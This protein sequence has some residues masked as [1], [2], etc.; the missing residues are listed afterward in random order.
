MKKI[1]RESL[2]LLF[3]VF[4][5]LLFVFLWKEYWVTP[6]L[7]RSLKEAMALPSVQKPVQQWQFEGQPNRRTPMHTSILEMPKIP[8]QPNDD[9][10]V[11]SRIFANRLWPIDGLLNVQSLEKDNA[12]L[13][14][15]MRQVASLSEREKF[16]ALEEWL[17]GN[18]GSRWA[19]ALKNELMGFKHK[20]GWFDVARQG[21]DE[22]WQKTKDRTDLPAYHLA[23]GVLG[24]LLEA[25]IGISRAQK[26]RELVAAADARPLNGA[27]EGKVFRAREAVWLL[28]HTAA[29]NVMCGPLALNAIKEF[30]REPFIAP[31]LSQVP[32]DYQQT[33][34]PLSEVQRY[35]QNDYHLELAMARRTDPGA[36][37]P[38]P[39]V[40]HVKDDHFNALL[41]VSADGT[42]YF[43]EDR[44]L[45]FAG[46]V[47]K[48]AVDQ[49]AT[50]YFLVAANDLG[51]GWDKV[52]AVTGSTVFGRDGAHGTT[53][54]E[55]TV[56]PYSPT[57]DPGVT[58]GSVRGGGCAGMPR[59][60]FLPMPG[61]IRIADIPLNYTPP[62]GPA[63]GFQINYNDM[64]SG[65]PTSPPTW[66]HVGVT[67]STN[68]VAWVEHVG[69]AL[70]NGTNL[71]VRLPGGGTEVVRYST[72]TAKFGPHDRSFATVTRTGTFTYTREL[73]DGSV[74][75]YNAP[76]HPTTPT[77]VFLSQI[78]D[79]QGNALTMAYDASIR[80]VSVTDAIGQVTTLSYTDAGNIYR[81]TQVTDPFG[82]FAT[83]TYDAG[84]R[85]TSVTDQINLASTFTYAAS[86]F[87]E[88]M[89]T[90]YGTSTFAKL[91]DSAGSNRIV[92]ATDPLG[93]KERVEFN[94]T[95]STFIPSLRSPPKSVTVGGQSVSFYAEDSRLQFR[96]GW[97]W[98]KLQSQVAPGD[99]KA[100]RNY[101]FYTNVN[102]Q[103]VPV[104]EN[105]KEPH[106]DRVWYN[107]PGGILIDSSG[108]PYY[109]GA[110]AAP[111]KVL[112]MLPDGTPQL[113]QTYTNA[114]G[115][116]IKSVD[117]LG[118]TTEYV[119][120]ANGLDVIEIKQTTGG[121][122]ERQRSIS[123]NARHLPLTIT[124]AAG[125]V[126]TYTYNARGQVLTLT[127]ALG[128]ATTFSYDA[129]G[130]LTSMDG[131]LPGASDTTTLT[132][133]AVGRIRTTTNTDGYTRTFSYDDF[134]RVTQIDYPDATNEQLTYDKLDRATFR[135][136]L[137]RITT[138]THN[139]IQQLTQVTDALNRVV[140]TVW[141]RCGNLAS[142]TDPMGRVTRWQHDLQGRVIAKIYA[143][144]SKVA[145]GYDDAGRLTRRTDEKGQNKLHDYF[146]DDSVSQ[147]SYP[148]AQIA[149]P[150]VSYTY[151]IVYPRM[152]GMK[153]GIGS[154]VYA[155][156]AVTNTTSLG[157]GSL[158]S[159]DGPFPDDT[160][161]YSYDAL[162]RVTGRAVNGV[163]AQ[164]TFDEL[165]RITAINDALGTS[166]A[167]FE[168]A[169]E[170][171]LQLVRSNGVTT[172][173][174]YFGNTNDRRLSQ[175]ENIRTGTGT[176]SKF[177]YT[178]DAVGRISTWSQQL[179]G[180][181]TPDLWTIVSDAVGQLQSVAVTR[182]ATAVSNSTYSYDAAGNRVTESTGG[183]TK[184][185][186]YDALNRL[187]DQDAALAGRTYQWDGENRLVGVMIGTKR[188]EFSYDGGGLCRRIREFNGKS[189]IDDATFVWDGM[190]RIEKRDSSGRGVL[191]RYFS[192][193]VQISSGAKQGSFTYTSDHL[194]S[195]R[196]VVSSA[197]TVEKRFQ[198][199]A[200]GVTTATAPGFAD[201]VGYTR[202][203]LHAASG[204]YLAPFRALDASF[205]RWLSRDPIGEDG[206]GINLYRYVSNDP[207]NFTDPTGLKLWYADKASDVCMR[208][209]I[210]E[211]MKSRKGRELLAKLHNDPNKTYYIHCVKG[212]GQAYQ[213]GDHVYVDP[214]IHPV[215]Q[216]DTGP[217][218]A[219]TA[220]ILA[221]EL[222][223]L[224]GTL[225]DGPNQLNNVNSWENPIMGP[226][227]GAN[228]TV[229]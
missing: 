14:G 155:Y 122:N 83:L 25:N 69:G 140:K 180:V 117:P 19:L 101:R 200:F 49:A 127:N 167:A 204:L 197:G 33:G 104:I 111:Q 91:V 159:L 67:W 8:D 106:E 40:M 88:S 42:E 174:A 58:G 220:R 148:N 214:D 79:P 10:L 85:L 178:Y 62:V 53:P 6:P 43:L 1:T 34:L 216:T 217:L 31:R 132:Y 68:W 47:D 99:Y 224:T 51:G 169:S 184:N 192:E 162:G 23:N 54:T 20:T 199:A 66:S 76:N 145:Y 82:R 28:D 226:L 75:I 173:F 121:I 228:R 207:I 179:G 64:D 105:T 190:A 50:G 72:V 210:K 22:I 37:I 153:D 161:A 172:N 163:A 15:L 185:S 157:A 3:V 112:R 151:D 170:R 61:A 168:G 92:E 203:Y 17:K 90:P 136:R 103:V 137:G 29:Q 71:R 27:L 39:A 11:G 193:G 52:D 149:T 223:H 129:N 30:K 138:Y 21:W 116:I 56:T 78:I 113:R 123:Y 195:V 97:Y 80:L 125:S 206:G 209:V 133:D 46:W 73:P 160:I 115:N 102:W 12:E 156:N 135:D 130:Y 211:L 126:T 119:Y 4:V 44:T 109:P 16:A 154:T 2:A 146:L 219:S 225:D 229:Y 218:P 191:V 84:G 108:F 86:G 186:R 93:G 201:D 63:V 107:Y 128:E 189:L 98:N 175:I 32:P 222:G 60:T 141:C 114:I 48:A 70:T 143:D 131:P 124:D 94:D 120:A 181:A 182:G 188:S 81:I 177:D 187:L 9:Q 176:L 18:G 215:I 144:N 24:S 152:V 89:T 36:K 142:L 13:G 95:G 205:G 41:A 87:I 171:P 221:H 59:Y 74:E 110:S 5:G 166:T 202:H 26:L 208:P 183:V 198:Y 57:T 77:R 38:T 158:A 45:G 55:E 147:I 100:A 96:N 212:T 35:A 227:E 165:G 65:A 139:A 7:Q 194:G 213:Q 150:S 118:R 164:I 196:E 134:D